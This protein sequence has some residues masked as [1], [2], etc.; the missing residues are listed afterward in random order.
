M[1]TVP[2]LPNRSTTPRG[3]STYD[4]FE[5][6][7]GAKVVVRESSAAIGPCV[8]V[9]LE[10]GGTERRDQGKINDGSGHFTYPQAIRLRNALDTFISE[11][12]E[13]WGAADEA[14]L[15]AMFEPE[16]EG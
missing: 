1:T 16:D 5:D 15:L 12:Q 14:E 8:W 3:F 10:G 7:Y 4:E 9:F 11:A 13:R 6:G 2:A